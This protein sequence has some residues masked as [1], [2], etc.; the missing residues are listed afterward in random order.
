MPETAIKTAPPPKAGT[1]LVERGIPL[2][3][4]A[5]WATGFI[6]ARLIAP[7]VGPLT[8]LSVRYILSAAVFVAISRLSGA[9]WPR[10]AAGWANAALV[11]LL[12]QGAYLAGV[13]WSVRHGLPAGLAGLLGGL[14]PLLTA[15]LAQ[16]LL[17]EKVGLLRWIGVFLGFGG[18]ALVLAPGLNATGGIQPLPVAICLIGVAGLTF[19]TI[20]QKRLPAAADLRSNAAIQFIAAGIVTIPAAQ[21]LEQPGWDFGMRHWAAPVWFGLAWAVL[22]LSFGAISLLLL[23]IRRGAV[24]AV[25]SMF[26]LVPPTAALIA[27]FAFDEILVPAQV[28]GMAVAAVG[29]AIA[30][31][32][33]S[34]R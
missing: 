28:V 6:V 7:H 12:M 2:L 16:R 14:Q 4:V 17:G 20:L 34:K 22:G 11:G 23:M 3:F 27:Y 9:A 21:W 15:L 13:F 8:F 10:T 19:G 32:A 25:A 31:R 1:A 33:P 29:V 30:S 5:I 18:A 24:S 26:Y